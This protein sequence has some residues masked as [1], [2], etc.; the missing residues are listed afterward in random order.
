MLEI[1]LDGNRDMP[2]GCATRPLVK[3][4]PAIARSSE[5]DVRVNE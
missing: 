4:G 3:L 1:G 5:L 2:T